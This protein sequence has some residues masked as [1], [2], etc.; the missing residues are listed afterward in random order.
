MTSA[1][2]RPV[3]LALVIATGAITVLATVDN[4]KEL[5]G[6]A[7]ATMAG[8]YLMAY[9]I[10]RPSSAWLAFAVLSALVTA[11]HLLRV[12][13]PGVA[14]TAVLVLLWLWALAA[15][16]RSGDAATLSLQTA[17]V[18]LFGALT[19]WCAAADLRPGLAI[20]GT[21]FLAHAAWDAYHYRADKVVSRSWS[22]FCAVVDL[23]VGVAL[24]VLAT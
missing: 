5:F 14:M 24:L 22:E 2:R 20:A 1:H 15:R 23:A 7:I 11:L 13:D 16:R 9:A 12:I 18:V 4:G 21:G 17:G 10:G 6:P 19:L 3:A 8:I